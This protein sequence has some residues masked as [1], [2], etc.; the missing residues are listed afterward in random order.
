MRRTVDN[1]AMSK[2]FK[3]VHSYAKSNNKVY[4]ANDAIIKEFELS[5]KKHEEL[6][7]IQAPA[8]YTI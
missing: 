3:N 1:R 6:A 5:F 8:G 7:S 2:D 4:V